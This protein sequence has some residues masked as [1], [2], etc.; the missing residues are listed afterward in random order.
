MMEGSKG[1]RSKGVKEEGGKQGRK[2]G[3]KEGRQEGRKEGRKGGSL[4]GLHASRM[5]HVGFCAARH[6]SQRILLLLCGCWCSK[7]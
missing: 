4:K 2:K 3:C 1:G 7:K 5:L 6:K